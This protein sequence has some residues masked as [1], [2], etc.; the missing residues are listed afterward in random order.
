MEDKKFYEEA[1]LRE[2][3]E[4]LKKATEELEKLSKLQDKID[5]LKK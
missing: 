4:R 5:E 1:E 3:L 2:D